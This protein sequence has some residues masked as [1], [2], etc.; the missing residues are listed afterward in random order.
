LVPSTERLSLVT[1]GPGTPP[2]E[3]D[4]S[5]ELE[6]LDSPE[7]ELVLV[8]LAPDDE[9]PDDAPLDDAR[10]GP[11]FMASPAVVGK[12]MFLRTRHHLYRIEGE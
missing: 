3:D 4:D 8:P 6:L 5:P 12:A 7:L 2:L 1:V 11:G 9:L 10:R